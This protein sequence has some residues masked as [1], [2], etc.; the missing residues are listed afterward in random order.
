VQSG[1]LSLLTRPTLH[2]NTLSN[3]ARS[4]SSHRLAK[5]WTT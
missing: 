5:D 4:A 3:E 2:K 1:G